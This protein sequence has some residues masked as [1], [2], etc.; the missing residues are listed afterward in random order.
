MKPPIPHYLRLK[1]FIL[2]N[3]VNGHWPVSSRI[4]SESELVGKFGISRMTVNRALRELT[5]AGVLN[6]IQ[7]VGTF[8]AGPKAES[9][10]FEVRNIREDLKARGEA[11]TVQVLANE[12]VKARAR[13]TSYFGLPTGSELFHSRLL[14]YGNGKPVQLEDRFVNPSLVPDYLDID[15]STEV[16]HQYL[17]RSAPLERAEHVIEAET[18]NQRLA[19]LLQIPAGGAL[20][21]LTRRTWSRQQM[22]SYV[23]L[24][25]PASRHRFVGAFEVGTPRNS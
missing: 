17:M 18:A 20:L 8:V 25:H 1:Q 15:L 3:I 14:H 4:P 22:V 10:M 24:I 7:G 19:S 2:R 13:I 23:R 11:H 21:V 6:R 12:A 5:D 16:P 9:A